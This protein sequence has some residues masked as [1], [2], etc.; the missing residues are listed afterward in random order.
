MK[1]LLF[2]VIP[3]LVAAPVPPAE[4]L[5]PFGADFPNLDSF[6][7]GAWWDK[8][9]PAKGKKGGGTPPPTML[10]ARDQVIAFALY[11][12]QAGVLKLSAQLYPLYPEEAK[13]ARLEVKRGDA[14]VE[15]AQAPVQFPG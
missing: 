8:K 2:L 7:V 15:V 4:T 14:W 3:M 5:K 6:A 11:T 10:V 1:F 9:P 12:Q 13:V